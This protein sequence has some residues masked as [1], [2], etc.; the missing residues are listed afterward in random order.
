M[1]DDASGN[2][3]DVD[4]DGQ[5]VRRDELVNATGDTDMLDVPDDVQEEAG[6]EGPDV[7]P[8]DDRSVA[9]PEVSTLNENIVHSIE[10]Q[11]P[12]PS[13]T[14]QSS[15]INRDNPPN[16]VL[17]LSPTSP[18][19]PGF[20]F[21]TSAPGTQMDVQPLL[22]PIAQSLENNGGNLPL[23]GLGVSPSAPTTSGFHF[24]EE[25]LGSN[26]QGG[27][28]LNQYS[29]DIPNN[30]SNFPAQTSSSNLSPDFWFG[31]KEFNGADL[32]FS[33]GILF[34][35]KSYIC[36]LLIFYTGIESF[37]DGSF[38]GA[39]YEPLDPSL[40]PSTTQSHA[41]PVP[42]HGL[43]DILGTTSPYVG[44]ITHP[45]GVALVKQPL[46]PCGQSLPGTFQLTQNS[47]PNMTAQDHARVSD[48]GSS[49]SGSQGH[50]RKGN[51]PVAK[52]AKKARTENT[53]EGTSDGIMAKGVGEGMAKSGEVKERGGKPTLSGRVPLLPT[54]LA[55]A[56][57]QGEKK[58][59]RARKV[60]ATKKPRSKGY[61]TKPAS[62]GSAKITKKRNK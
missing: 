5:T 9:N 37:P 52:P 59:V 26:R 45:E 39:L 48:E 34:F 49:T 53:A 30:W 18:T 31:N 42:L 20:Q 22:A 38:L 60:K 23:A 54:H 33:Q 3:V 29:C 24:P 12:L 61:T 41:L 17:Q 36:N 35:I 32:R 46:E 7:Q 50:K 28:T 19:T 27:G 15:E 11:Q 56:G 13:P 16:T 21:L 14:T 10:S 47:S 57:Y 1:S 51:E 43:Q 4:R 25:S 6:L 40:I 8:L 44:A 55:E 2:P 62:K 58:G